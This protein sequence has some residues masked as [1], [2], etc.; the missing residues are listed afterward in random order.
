[1]ENEIK[2]ITLSTVEVTPP[3]TKREYLAFQVLLHDARFIDEGSLRAN[4]ASDVGT[5]FLYAD[6]FM[7]VAQLTP[8]ALAEEFIPGRKIRTP[9]DVAQDPPASKPSEAESFYPKDVHDWL[10]VAGLVV[11]I[12]SSIAGLFF[13]K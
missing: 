1:M 6:E 8:L 13:P 5:A 7:R 2:T 4:C 12:L 10:F 11:L 9:L 3:L